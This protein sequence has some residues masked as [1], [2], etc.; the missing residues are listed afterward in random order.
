MSS[1]DKIIPLFRLIQ[2]YKESTNYTIGYF[3]AITY[4]RLKFTIHSLKYK[5]EK[6]ED[7]NKVNMH[8][9]TMDLVNIVNSLSFSHRFRTVL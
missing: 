8:A 2:K 1:G 3:L 6:I 5:S 7:R 9:E 4:T